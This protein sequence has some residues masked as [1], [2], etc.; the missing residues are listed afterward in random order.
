MA[1][2]DWEGEDYGAAPAR[3]IAS[4]RPGGKWTAEKGAA[5]PVRYALLGAD[6]V[7]GRF[8]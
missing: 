6:A 1:G 7:S 3:S 5:L 8:V 2:T 4:P